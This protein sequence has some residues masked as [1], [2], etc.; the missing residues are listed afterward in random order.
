MWLTAYC[1]LPTAYCI[2]PTAYFHRQFHPHNRPD[3]CGESGLVETGDAVDAV[4][5]DERHRRVAQL[6][7]TI[8]ERFG[9]RGSLEKAEGG[10]GVEFDVGHTAADRQTAGSR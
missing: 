7:R 5:I 3:P 8:D 9:Q 1:I 10:R 2:L 4:A 6:R